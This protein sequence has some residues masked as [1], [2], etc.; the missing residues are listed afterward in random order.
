MTAENTALTKPNKD[1][2]TLIESKSFK[3]ELARALPNRAIQ[4]GII[5]PDHIVRLART[6]IMASDALLKCSPLS[7][8][9]CVIE[10]AQ[11]GLELEK[12][13]GHAYL[14]PFSGECTLIVG[15][16]GFMHLAY[17]S[18]ATSSISAEIVR[19]G[20]KFKRVLG[21]R[22]ELQHAPGPI[23]KDDKSDNWLGAYAVVE[24]LSGRTDFEYMEKVQIEAARNRSNSW[25]SWIKFKKSTPWV[26]DEAEMW[27]KTP[28][29]RLAKRLPMSTTDKRAELLRA[30][31]IDEYG[32]RKGLLVPTLHGF[33]VVENPPE[34]E[35]DEPLE[36]TIEVTSKAEE[37][38]E[39]A[40]PVEK[41][42]KP[43]NPPT[44]KPIDVKPANSG[45]PK[46]VIP[47]A[48]EDPVIDTKQQTEIF[49]AAVSSGWKVPDE[50]N[51]YLHKTYR[52][53]SIRQ[54]RKSQ[55]SAVLKVMKEGT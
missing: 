46:A 43:K 11:L 23:P 50:V 53:T 42:A 24:F 36:P 21:T 52:I 32:E 20:D 30:V 33:E 9:A 38:Q 34:P 25:R 2:L 41:S 15:Y 54:V 37:K 3:D 14:V 40:A 31:M 1:V 22:R 35:S 8:T 27:R 12:V 39:K 44:K 47:P 26:T 48:S 5:T 13:M 45:V 17:Q 51:A 49:S 18:G 16:R 29:R 10:S 4:S 6:M 19:R 7:I 28:V 55:F